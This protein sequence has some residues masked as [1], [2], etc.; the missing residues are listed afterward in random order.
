MSKELRVVVMSKM[1]ESCCAVGCS[2]RKIKGCGIPF[3][4]I[5][6]AKTPFEAR[7]RRDWIKAINRDVLFHKHLDC[8]D[9]KLL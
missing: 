7:R 5:S 9:C 2:Q 8:L 6:K 4:R 1:P 3:Y